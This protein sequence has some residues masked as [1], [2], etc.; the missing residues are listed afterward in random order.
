[1][2]SAMSAVGHPVH[3]LC[4]PPV[5]IASP[6]QQDRHHHSAPYIYI[7]AGSWLPAQMPAT[8]LDLKSCTRGPPRSAGKRTDTTACGSTACVSTACVST[9]AGGGAP[10]EAFEDGR[11]VAEEGVGFEVRQDEGARRR[12][13]RLV[14]APLLALHC[15][16]N[17]MHTLLRQ[18]HHRSPANLHAPY[19]QGPLR[20]SRR[21]APPVAIRLSRTVSSHEK[22]CSV[23]RW[24]S[25]SSHQL[26]THHG[27]QFKLDA[28]F[29]LR[30]HARSTLRSSWI[31]IPSYLCR[32]PQA[33]VVNA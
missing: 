24:A 10:Q 31:A 26:G 4:A 13:P 2:G 5:A 28:L 19:L 11:V 29:Q 3:V 33:D 20:P 8:R 30:R 7:P 16:L 1:M 6:R 18:L 15:D 12:R 23:A 9:A 17:D 14:L 21:A 27:I 22:T 32:D 25:R